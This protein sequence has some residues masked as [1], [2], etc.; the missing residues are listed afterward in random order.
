MS[1]KNYPRTGS[2]DE[3]LMAQL[4]DP[5]EARLYL[6][7]S[8][9][10]YE[11]DNDTAAFLIALREVAEAQGGVAKLANRTGLNRQYLYGVLSGEGSKPGL[12]NM[13]H[14]LSG[15]GFRLRLENNTQRES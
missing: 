9:E 7:A 10:A 15:L 11:E 6:E 14:I 5:E 12:D 4:S 1:R 3:Y 8:L 13:L 2:Y